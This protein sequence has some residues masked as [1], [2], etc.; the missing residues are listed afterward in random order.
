MFI[1]GIKITGG[2][3]LN[4]EEDY[5]IFVKRILPTGLAELDGTIIQ[6]TLKII[7]FEIFEKLVLPTVHNN[8]KDTFYSD[9]RLWI[10]L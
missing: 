8:S 7:Q 4:N 1:S 2:C 5:G 6:Q 10:Y 3:S 9:A